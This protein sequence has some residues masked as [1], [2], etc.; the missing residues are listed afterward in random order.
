[1]AQPEV[2]FSEFFGFYIV[3]TIPP[4]L[5]THLSLPHEVCNSRNHAAHYHTLDPQLEASSVT[6]LW[7]GL[8][9]KVGF[10]MQSMF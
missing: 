8:E 10:T 3:I 9:V 5:H 7:A 6:Q 2:V 4:Y 1:V